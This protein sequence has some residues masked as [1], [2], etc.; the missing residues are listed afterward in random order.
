LNTSTIPTS[1]AIAALLNN[2]I[3]ALAEIRV[4]NRVIAP[5]YDETQTYAVGSYCMFKDIGDEYTKL[6]KCTTAVS[7]PEDFDST[8]WTETTIMQ[9]ILNH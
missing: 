4:D 1:N 2:P 6:Y 7:A 3:N 8:K 9:E 5:Y